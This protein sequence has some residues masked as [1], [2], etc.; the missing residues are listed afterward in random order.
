MG[1]SAF[2]GAGVFSATRQHVSSLLCWSAAIISMGN[3]Q[4][5][6]ILQSFLLVYD[7]GTKSILF[8]T[9]DKD[10]WLNQ[11]RVKV[12]DC[13]SFFKAYTS[14]VN[15][16]NA[17]KRTFNSSGTRFAIHPLD[18]QGHDRVA[19][20]SHICRSRRGNSQVWK[21]YRN[22]SEEGCAPN[23]NLIPLAGILDFA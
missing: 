20:H 7:S 23:A 1:H 19:L 6:F 11:C 16:V 22:R 21:C 17:C 14:L 10:I 15:T 12:N 9:L 3:V 18:I 2:A 8:D 13:F 4:Q 5:E